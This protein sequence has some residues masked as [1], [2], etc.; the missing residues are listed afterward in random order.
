MGFQSA[1]SEFAPYSKYHRCWRVRDIDILILF[2]PRIILSSYNSIIIVDSTR[3][4]KRL[5]DALS[6]TIPIW[7][8]V[9]NLTVLKS[10]NNHQSNE[11]TSAEWGLHTPTGSGR[12]LSR[13]MHCHRT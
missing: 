13:H 3:Q 9:I 10:S 4:G 8:A 12:I 11:L 5:P 1:S 2:N 7:C 6:K